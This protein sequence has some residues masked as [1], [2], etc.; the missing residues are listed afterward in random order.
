MDD[1][2]LATI[3]REHPSTV[4]ELWL[5]LRARDG[6]DEESFVETVQRLAAEDVFALRRPNYR[7]E[8]FLDY[9]FTLSVSGWLW[10]TFA[11]VLLSVLVVAI[12]PAS[13]SLS[14]VRWGLG[15]LFVLYL[16]GFALLRLLYPEGS[17]LRGVELLILNVGVS[18]AVVPLVGLI[19]N[20]TPWGIRL[21]PVVASLALFTMCFAAAGALREY[22][23]D[24][25]GS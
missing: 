4:G 18:L 6:A 25:R 21:E 9:L 12:I 7:F 1:L 14:P 10:A 22:S 5:M 2:I 13:S 11:A 3:R 8:R 17:R 19:L 24:S 23:K 16:P 20:F 15:L